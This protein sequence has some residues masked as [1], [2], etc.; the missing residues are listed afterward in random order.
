[1]A[2][3]DGSAAPGGAAA[4]AAAAAAERDLFDCALCLKLF[5][6]PITL[7][8]GHTYCRA[9]IGRALA[10]AQV[11]PLCRSPCWMATATARP[12]IVISRLIG[13]RYAAEAEARAVE[14]VEEEEEIR[15][16]RLGLFIIDG[17]GTPFPGSPILLFVFE[18][19]YLLLM[20]RCIE[21]AVPFGVQE[22]VAAGV[23]ATVTVTDHSRLPDGRMMVRGVVAHRYRVTEPPTQEAGSYGLYTAPTTLLRDAPLRA[24]GEGTSLPTDAPPYTTLPL[25]AQVALRSA[26]SDA[27]R[28]TALRDALAAV[29][30]RLFAGLTPQQWRALAQRH[31]EPPAPDGLAATP[32]RWSFY[33]ADVLALDDGTRRACWETVDTYARLV[34]CYSFVAAAD[35]AVVA[36]IA[37]A[38]GAPPVA[39]PPPG[40]LGLPTLVH[41]QPGQVFAEIA[42]GEGGLGRLFG[43]GGGAG[44]GAGGIG[45]AVAQLVAGLRGMVAGGL[46]HSGVYAAVVILGIIAAVWAFRNMER[47]GYYYV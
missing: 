12:S 22:A 34:R 41:V 16:A 7:A 35:A 27:E 18:P 43:L 13:A 5:H 30:T 23:G 44:G 26:G 8:C 46:A 38:P 36:A 9:C 47:G 25:A 37:S 10:M 28:A 6:E 32:A 4:A 42:R 19:R 39:P 29:F 45:G 2:S 20:G 11:C 40:P 1:M 14:F 33:A 15:A 3:A 21:N 24:R 17:A 31:G